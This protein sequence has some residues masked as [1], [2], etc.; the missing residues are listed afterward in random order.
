MD[1]A[2]A[3][4]KNLEYESDPTVWDQGIFRPMRQALVDLVKEAASTDFGIFIFSPDDIADIRG[5][6][7]HVVR[8]NVLF[9][10]GLFIGAIGVERCFI[11]APRGAASLHLPSDLLGLEPLRYAAD[12]NDGRI[13]AALGPASHEILTEIRAQGKRATVKTDSGPVLHGPVSDVLLDIHRLTKRFI[14]DWNGLEL[15]P[16]RARLRSGVPNH[17]M[18]DDDG[19]ATEAVRNVFHFLNTMA[20]ALISGRL[21]EAKARLV[22]EEPV[23]NVW[24][25]SATYLAPLNQADEAWDPLPAIAQLDRRWRRDDL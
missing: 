21:D 13:R 17:L 7:R 25:H 3:L 18:E 1:V 19:T 6:T 16:Y 8:D 22:F 12:R 2:Y 9:E 14:D 11:V 24:A 23:K 10:L 20:E 4:Q 15:A 5:E